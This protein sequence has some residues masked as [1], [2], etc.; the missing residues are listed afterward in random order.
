MSD[1]DKREKLEAELEEAS[2]SAMENILEHLQED[3]ED[4]YYERLGLMTEIG[5]TRDGWRESMESRLY[6]ILGNRTGHK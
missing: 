3:I 1:E 5:C 2:D 6:F 4:Q